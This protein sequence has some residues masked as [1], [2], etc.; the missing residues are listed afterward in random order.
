MYK[1]GISGIYNKVYT[2]KALTQSEVVKDGSTI[3]KNG[4]DYTVAYKNNI[5]P[6]KATMTITGKGNY[7][8]YVTWTFK[9][10]PKKATLVSLKSLNTRQLT[11]T[12]K[13][14]SLASGYKVVIGTNSACTK[15]V[16]SKIFTSNKTTSKTFTKLLKGKVYYAKV[17]AYK[18]IDGKRYYGAYSDVRKLKIK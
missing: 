11:V 16:V 12:W 9:I 1:L 17:R 6:G 3:L 14:D 8:G 4:T 15:N 5:V 7:Q 13:R 2:G 18:V 10:V